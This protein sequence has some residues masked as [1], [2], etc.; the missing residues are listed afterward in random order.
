MGCHNAI[1]PNRKTG[2]SQEVRS[3]LDPGHLA[4]KTE[5]LPIL[6]LAHSFFLKEE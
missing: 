3:H 2:G 5:E 1:P 6:Q 4:A